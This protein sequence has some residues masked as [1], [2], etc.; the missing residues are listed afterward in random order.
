MF[1]KTHP[2]SDILHRCITS[3]PKLSVTFEKLNMWLVK[4][5]SVLWLVNRV[6]RVSERCPFRK[7]KS[8]SL[9]NLMPFLISCHSWLV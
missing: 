6:E 5:T 7:H 1:K 3:L 9:I 2:F 4:W 8:S